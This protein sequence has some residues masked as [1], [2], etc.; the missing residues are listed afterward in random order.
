MFTERAM[1]YFNNHNE[2][3]FDDT[4][5]VVADLLNMA[6]VFGHIYLKAVWEK[7]VCDRASSL[8]DT[9][10]RL[11]KEMLYNNL[12]SL[13]KVVSRPVYLNGG[14]FLVGTQRGSHSVKLQQS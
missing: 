10:W 14:S 12:D 11:Q 2:H 9:R 5:S 3:E 4:W 13:G 6:R 1:Y 8:E 7:K